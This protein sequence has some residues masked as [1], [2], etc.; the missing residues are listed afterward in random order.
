MLLSL[1]IP[2]YN[3]KHKCENLL[4]TLRDID[5]HEVEIILVDD[6]SVDGT[7]ELLEKFKDDSKITT[8]VI[9]QDNKGPGG[10]RNHGLSV[11]S[12]E[13]VWFIDSDDNINLNAIDVIKE[14]RYGSYD[15]IDFDIWHR[16]E[17][18]NTLGLSPGS[19]TDSEKSKACLLEI[20]G[21][22]CC[23]VFRRKFLVSNKIFYPE[24]CLYEDH[25][26][27]FIYPF[28]VKHFY[29]SNVVGYY[30]NEE[31]ESVTRCDPSPRFFDKLLTLQYGFSR[32]KAMC[33]SDELEKIKK[34]FAVHYLIYTSG[35]LITKKPS[36]RWIMIARLMR[37]Y[38]DVAK[39]NSIQI[40]PLNHLGGS[41][42]YK[43][44]FVFLWVISCMLPDQSKYFHKLRIEGWKVDFNPPVGPQIINEPYVK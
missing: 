40:N 15:F 24:C 9:Y 21:R 25:P 22:L 28:F 35:M 30:H 20:F 27:P 1:I 44:F 26:M 33:N 34:K 17:V 6:G 16:G 42:G 18:I 43:V 29:K 8:Q 36:Y 19:Y 11:A 3:S 10:A 41:V 2:F 31:F 5:D 32:S 13:Y 12:G 38:R 14:E 39:E 37:Q 7:G 4:K 23:K